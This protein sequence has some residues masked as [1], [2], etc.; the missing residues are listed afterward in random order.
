MAYICRHGCVGSGFNAVSIVYISVLI[1]LKWLFHV[2]YL[3]A[4][5][6][7]C[8]SNS[9]VSRLWSSAGCV[10]LPWY[11]RAGEST[12]K[13]KE[14]P[15]KIWNTNYKSWW[16]TVSSNVC[17]MPQDRGSPSFND[18]V[19]KYLTVMMNIRLR[20]TQEKPCHRIDIGLMKSFFFFLKP[21]FLLNH[22]AF[23]PCLLLHLSSTWNFNLKLTNFN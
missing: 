14:T 6:E 2:N 16:G 19:P 3:T 17:S 10:C 5:D 11:S 13:I 4:N 15:V 22:T 12:I 20:A 8:L 21:P 18:C 1:I 23:F 7:Q 9:C